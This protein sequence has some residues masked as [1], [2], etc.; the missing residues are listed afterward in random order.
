MSDL[1]TTPIAAKLRASILQQAIEGKLVP[2]DPNDEP[3]SKLVERIRGE[4]AELVKQKKAKAPKGGES[5]IW[6]DGNGSWWERRG[7]SEAVRID[8][9]IPF[10]IPENWTWCRLDAIGQIIG[11]GTPKTGNKAYWASA[12][13]GIPWITPADMKFVSGT[14]VN[15]GERYISELGLKESSARLLPEGSVVMSSR[16]PIGYLALAGCALAT[17]QGFKSVV[18]TEKSM[19]RWIM[20]SV[21]ARMNDI[22]QRASGTTFAEIS[23]AEFGRTLIP[24]P[25]MLEQRRIVSKCDELRPL[26]DQLEILERESDAVDSAFWRDLPRAVLQ[27]AVQGNLV[28]QDPAEGTSSELVERIREERRRLIAEKKI[29]PIKGGE[30]IIHRDSAGH[31]FE[32]RGKNAPVCIDDE[33]PFEIPDSWTW[34]RL[35]FAADILSGQAFKS[36]TFKDAGPYRLLRGINLGVDKVRWNETVFLDSL[37]VNAERYELMANDLLLGMD[38][39]WI[40]DGLRT[41]L[42]PSSKIPTYLV[43][44]VLRIRG[45]GTLLVEYLKIIFESGMLK[46]HIGNQTTGISVPHISQS[47]VDSLLIPI[48]PLA[49]QQR[50]AE[51]VA[52]FRFLIG[53]RFVAAS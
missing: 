36:E 11:G 43:Q 46:A 28:P 19:N 5:I 45:I 31:W 42:F 48:L 6:K 20:L 15:R 2:Q 41:A 18:P 24:L 50:I 17:N 38:R 14:T 35:G 8:D 22:K 53:E 44:R 12:E 34:A 29:K 1:K 21:N 10:D 4:R 9:E 33:I 25:P 39:P 7:K 52:E 37:P 16:A 32:T 27:Q 13:A 47:Q 3:A 23:G 30:S 51:K 49:E 40:N 26:T